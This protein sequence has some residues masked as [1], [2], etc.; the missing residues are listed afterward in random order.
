[1]TKN[2]KKRKTNFHPS[3][4]IIALRQNGWKKMNAA[5]LQ[6]KIPFS[7]HLRYFMQEGLL[8]MDFQRHFF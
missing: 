1:M 5:S 8:T 3:P 7:H 2:Y 4:G 6:K